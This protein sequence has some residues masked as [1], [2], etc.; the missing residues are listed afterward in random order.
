[1]LLWHLQNFLS[2]TLL[3]ELFTNKCE[4]LSCKFIKPCKNQKN[5][6][7][8][9]RDKSASNSPPCQGNVRIPPPQARC[10]VKCPGYAQG[11]GGGV[12]ASIWVVHYLPS[13][14]T[15]FWKFQFLSGKNVFHLELACSA[16][17][18]TSFMLVAEM[19]TSD[20]IWQLTTTVKE[21]RRN[22]EDL[23]ETIFLQWSMSF[24]GT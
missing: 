23:G 15:N 11:E 8:K 5:S 7:S 18:D 17:C 10:T 3:R 1:M 14:Y 16:R 20:K 2:K 22:P 19:L 6:L 12:E 4:I 13:A 9:A 21:I 24:Y